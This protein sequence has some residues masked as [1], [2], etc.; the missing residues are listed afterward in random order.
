MNVEQMLFSCMS[1][2]FNG[3]GGWTPDL[4]GS[5]GEMNGG[6]SKWTVLG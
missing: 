6:G 4:N 2:L 1:C 3:R 5:V